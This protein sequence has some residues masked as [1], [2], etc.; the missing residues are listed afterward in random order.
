M[1]AAEIFNQTSPDGVDFEQSTAYHRLV[2][3]AF[4]TCGLLLDLHGEGLADDWR[5]RLM[6]MV[7]FVEAYVKP[8]GTVPLIGDADDGRVQK[9]G[10]QALADHRY[11]LSLGAAL[12]GRADFKRAARRFHEE[13][14]WLIGP[15]GAAVFDGVPA[16]DAAPESRDFPGGGF[17]VL[18]SERAH[19]IVDCGEVGMH[20]R[21]GHGHNDILSC[22][23][24]LDGR[25]LVTDCGAYLYTA[26]PEWRNHFRS[27]AFHNV[28][29]VDGEEV[30]R[31]PVPDNLWRLHDDARPRDVVWQPGRDVDYFRGAHS[32]YLR[33]PS[34]VAV[35]REIALV[36]KGPD[37]LVRDRLEG[38]GSHVL[39]WRFHLAPSTS[40]EIRRG[41]VCLLAAGREA[42]LQ[43]M[44]RMRGLTMTVED[45][46]VS[47]SYG[48]RTAIRVI[49][50]RG[51]VTLPQTASCRFGL[52]R[53]PPERLAAVFASSLPAETPAPLVGA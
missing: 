10:P 46:W 53:L 25:T 23:I 50:L 36:K 43:W 18:R 29:Q 3:E 21:G 30:N 1:V 17:Y 39:T 12:F 35:T 34:P 22:E 13:S 31:F 24:W 6:Q 15:E 47:P 45:G 48:V 51:R 27:T 9:L 16:P 2:L 26:S 4:L 20:G 38:I 11:L 44:P 42:W 14:F 32:G 40:A 28:V 41:D 19:V 7:E 52:S 33:L 5:T 8:D 49:V 37:V